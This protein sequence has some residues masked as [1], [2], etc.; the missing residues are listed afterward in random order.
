MIRSVRE[1]KKRRNGEKKK[2]KQ[3]CQVSLKLWVWRWCARKP[4]ACT[5]LHF[6]KGVQEFVMPVGQHVQLIAN[7][8]LREFLSFRCTGLISRCQL[9]VYFNILHRSKQLKAC[10]EFQSTLLFLS[11]ANT[12]YP[13][14]CLVSDL[15]YLCKTYAPNWFDMPPKRF[16]STVSSVSY[17][18]FGFTVFPFT[19]L[20]FDVGYHSER[21][22]VVTVSKVDDV[23]DGGQH[24]TL[25]ACPNGSISLTHCQQ[26]LRHQEAKRF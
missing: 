6:S 7:V 1:K 13:S 23:G 18:L 26:K 15:T 24:S 20:L 9:N 22:S 5:N 8:L 16:L 14:D 19:G 3:L 10:R 11:Q 21:C 25:T 17:L 4:K 2:T 12:N